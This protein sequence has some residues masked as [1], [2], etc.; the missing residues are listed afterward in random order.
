MMCQFLLLLFL[1]IEKRKMKESKRGENTKA[2]YSSTFTSHSLLHFFFLFQSRGMGEGGVALKA[3]T[4]FH[5]AAWNDC[6]S[7]QLA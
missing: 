6:L 1:G 5:P 7:G 2:Y 4:L 3:G